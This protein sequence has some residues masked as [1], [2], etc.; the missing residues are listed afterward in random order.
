[1]KLIKVIN[2]EQFKTYAKDEVKK[3][4][5]NNKSYIVSRFVDYPKTNVLTL[6]KQKIVVD[7]INKGIDIKEISSILG[8]PLSTL[9]MWY[10]HSRCGGDC[11]EQW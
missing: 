2:S 3:V 8:V 11:N 5:H 4:T 1:M 9:A 10:S 7:M 6:A